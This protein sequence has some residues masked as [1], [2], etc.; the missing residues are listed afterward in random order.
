MVDG[1]LL[2]WEGV[3]VDTGQ[4]RREAMLRALAEEGVHLAPREYDERCIG[5]SVRE[6]AASAVGDAASDR[7]LVELVAM[8]A[9]REFSARL[10]HGFSLRPGAARMVELAQLRAPIAIVTTASRTE[11]DVVLRLAD[12]HD[13]CAVLITADDVSDAAASRSQYEKALAGL[14]RRRRVRPSHIIALA[15]NRSSILA[16]RDAGVRTIAVGTPAHVALEADGA[17]ASLEGITVDDLAVVAGLSAE[18]RH[19]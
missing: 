13:S 18:E 3:L 1:V 14:A 10:A 9:E 6:A 17:V 11:T 5:R 7:T 4:S 8:R 12:L 2:D 19:A 15:A 16:A